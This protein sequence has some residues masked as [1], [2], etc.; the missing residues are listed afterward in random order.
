[1]HIPQNDDSR[2][3][4]GRVNPGPKK[5]E[6]RGVAETSRVAH[7]GGWEKSPLRLLFHN[8]FVKNKHFLKNEGST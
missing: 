8:L 1:M 7:A 2:K 6:F 3:I 5:G 4:R